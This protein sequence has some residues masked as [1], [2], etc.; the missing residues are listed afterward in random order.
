M[1]ADFLNPALLFIFCGPNFP[2]LFLLERGGKKECLGFS[3][4]IPSSTQPNRIPV[5]V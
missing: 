1:D 2:K 3:F 4:L 5:E